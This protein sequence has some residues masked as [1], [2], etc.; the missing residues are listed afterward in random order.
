VV[1]VPAKALGLE[2]LPVCT[3]CTVRTDCTD[4]LPRTTDAIAREEQVIE[5]VAG[6]GAGAGAGAGC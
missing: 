1:A 3:V 6:P 5:L 4:V 2:I